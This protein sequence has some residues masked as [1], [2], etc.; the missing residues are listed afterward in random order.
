[1]PAE[2]LSIIFGKLAFDDRLRSRLCSRLWHDLMDPLIFDDLNTCPDIGHKLHCRLRFPWL[3]TASAPAQLTSHMA[4]MI[5]RT[6]NTYRMKE[7]LECLGRSARYD[8]THAKDRAYGSNEMRRVLKYGD[9]V[10]D[11]IVFRRMTPGIVQKDRLLPR[12]EMNSLRVLNLCAPTVHHDNSV[13]LKM[14][15]LLTLQQHFPSSLETL[16]FTLC[17]GSLV[18]PARFM[19]ASSSVTSEDTEDEHSFEH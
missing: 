10:R 11:F 12:F 9:F 8:A 14:T 4:W 17:G 2:L 18:L 3:E 6:D 1:L 5:I 15:D 16:R 19:D 7:V 13:L